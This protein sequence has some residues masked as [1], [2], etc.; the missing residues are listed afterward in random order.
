M[1]GLRD[2]P[3]SGLCAHRA[4]GSNLRNEKLTASIAPTAGYNSGYFD[5]NAIY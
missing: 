4:I 1:T 2:V 3:R 5:S